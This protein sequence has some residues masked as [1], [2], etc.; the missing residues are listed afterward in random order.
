[1]LYGNKTIVASSL[2]LLLQGGI[3]IALLLLASVWDIRKPIILDILCLCIALISL[4]AVEPVKLFG[5][6]ILLPFLLAAL[7]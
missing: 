1:M 3:F 6:L 5:I 4:I 7:L 2:P